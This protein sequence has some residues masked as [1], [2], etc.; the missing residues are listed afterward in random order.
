MNETSDIDETGETED[1]RV[2]DSSELKNTSDSDESFVR[3]QEE[4]AGAEAGRIGG[5]GSDEEMDPAMRPLAEAGQ[6]ESEGFEDAEAELIE[7]A[8]HGDPGP[9]P[10]NMAGKPEGSGGA[11]ATYGEA[12][13]EESVDDV[14]GEGEDG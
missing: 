3:E 6:G 1:A 9:D 11:G 13:H 14:A 4:A 7:H 12:D 8:S 5:Q 2:S 10:M